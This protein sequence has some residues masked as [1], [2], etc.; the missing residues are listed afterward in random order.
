MG[1]KNKKTLIKQVDENLNRQFQTGKGR[2]KHADKKGEGTQGKIYSEGTLKVYKRNCCY[3]V[4]WCK[5]RYQCKTLKDCQTHA[6]E[7]I[8]EQKQAGLSAWTLKT[9]ASSVAKLYGVPACE[10]GIET[11]PRKRSEIKRSRH[12]T[13]SDAHF[14]EIKNYKIVTFGRCTGLRR[15]ELSRIT[16]EALYYKD[17][18]P[19]LHVTKGT[20]GGRP[21]EAPI[22]GTPEEVA[23]VIELLRDAGSRRV[24]CL[25]PKA[26]DEHA[27]RKEYA[28]RVYQ[29]HKRPLSELKAHQKYYC[30]GELMGHVYDRRA[31]LRASEALG[32]GR[33]SIIASNYSPEP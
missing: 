11:P 9:R 2:S 13:K 31:M 29:K 20:K 27:N 30:R 18:E 23:L 17:G 24:F 19:Y 15:R 14:S 16:G 6:A 22:V 3:F 26:M 28:N 33:L 10:L 21:R 12:V 1:H 8:E 4:V 25:V 32:H 5:Y 7:W